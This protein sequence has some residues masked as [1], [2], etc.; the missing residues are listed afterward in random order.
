MS[1]F[2]SNVSAVEGATYSDPFAIPTTGKKDD[3][4]KE[5]FLLLLVE[6]LKNQDPLEP[7]DGTDF[8]AQLA[9]FSSLEQQTATN[10]NLT[11][12]QE[13]SA[14]LNRLNAL[15][16]IGREVEFDL[17]GSGS[18]KIA[19]DGQPVAL[20]FELA[21]NAQEV[22][23]DIFNQDGGRVAT[24]ELG[25]YDLGSQEYNWNGKDGEGNAL[26]AGD[27]TYEVYARDELGQLVDVAVNGSGEVTGIETDP[28]NGNTLLVLLS[29]ARIGIDQVLAVKTPEG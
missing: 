28:Q 29:G 9:Q 12:L 16:M 10:E 1:M 25:Y 19:G 20:N 5:D 23:I 26:P 15:N 4:G 7:M 17:G 8:T 27:Y 6:Q 24:L 14:T 11:L 3:I 22:T 18:A 21:D 2:N 13:Y